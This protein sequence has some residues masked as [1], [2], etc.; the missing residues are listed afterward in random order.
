MPWHK[1]HLSLDDITAGKQIRIQEEFE[2]L[3]IAVHG[4]KDMA[5]F[6]GP[7]DDEGLEMFFSPQAAR[8]AKG[9]IDKYGGEECEQPSHAGLALLV[10]HS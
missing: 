8:F 2:A 3:F 5:L 4:P 10:G 6:S 9:L 1:I 7:L